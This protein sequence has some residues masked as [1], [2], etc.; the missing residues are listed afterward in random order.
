MFSEEADWILEKLRK[1]DLRGGEKALNLGS[2]DLA[3]RRGKQ[4]YQEKI[5]N[6][7]AARGVKVFHLDKRAGEGID[8]V[9]DIANF[10]SDEVYDLVFLTNVLEHLERPKAVA[11][12]VFGLLAPNG[13]LF[14]TVPRFYRYHP[15]PIDTGF[16]P[17]KRE[18]ENLFPAGKVLFS[19]VISIRKPNDRLGKFLSRFGI[20]WQVT[21][22]VLKRVNT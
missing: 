20:R 8:I 9:A 21:C 18:L 4:P 6:F 16:R 10:S 11:K 5:F 7:L 2:G 1:I 13:H 14:V 17:S 22:L 15:D 12:K 19:E 3:F